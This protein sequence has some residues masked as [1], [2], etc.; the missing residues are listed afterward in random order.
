V[1]VM[2]QIS[3]DH[4]ITDVSF[5]WL[6]MR[7]ALTSALYLLTFQVLIRVLMVVIVCASVIGVRL[8][9]CST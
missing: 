8:R 7:L 5:Q 4:Q 3:I 6:P 2:Q 9:L 1:A